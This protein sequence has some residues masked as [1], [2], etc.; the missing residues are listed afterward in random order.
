MVPAIREIK[1]MQAAAERRPLAGRVAVVTGSA[2]NIGR[3]IACRL[4]QD[5]AAVV[6]NSRRHAEQVDAVVNEI[7]AAGGQAVGCLADITDEQ[8]VQR[9]IGCAVENFGR[10]DILVNNAAVRQE[11]A[12]ATTSLAEWRNILAVIL[13]GAFLCCRTALPYLI[14]SDAAT[15][16]NV[17]GMTGSS[18]AQSR[19]HVVTAKAGLIGL[20]KALACDLASD[21][22]TVN[23]VS[24]GMVQTER[25][26]STAPARPKH[27]KVHEPLLGRR[28]T[29][30]EIAA[31]VRMLCGPDGRF[32]TGQTLHVNGGA[33]LP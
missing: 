28:G 33:Y 7:H 21:N 29:P 9:L 27:H 26:T 18:G 31:V 32:V 22:V 10:L 19:V 3:A 15:I 6:I 14:A 4:A 2:R 20:T 23:L 13:D 30:E 11:G 24:P 12:L 1:S 25:D 8:A 16:V 5:G 17:G